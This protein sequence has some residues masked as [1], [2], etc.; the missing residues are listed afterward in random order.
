MPLTH[1]L[2][3][4]PILSRRQFLT[5]LG[6]AGGMVNSPSLLASIPITTTVFTPPERRLKLHNLHTGEH[7]DEA[8]WANGQYLNDGINSINTL[9][10][11]HR[12]N[13]VAH[14]DRQL[15]NILIQLQDKLGYQGEIEVISGYR[16]AKTNEM[17]RQQG[18][19]VS[20]N[21]LHLQ[22][23]AIDIRIPSFSVDDIFKSVSHLRAG[24]VGKYPRSQF[25]HI[26]TGRIRYWG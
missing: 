21:S 18:R 13:Q 10:R 3:R 14:M 8:F 4:Q 19:N 17:L 12:C 2:T 5:Y 26:D 24:G 1:Q 9:L 22:G 20:K 25:V 16:S 6:I 15:F 23:K 7:L 11:D